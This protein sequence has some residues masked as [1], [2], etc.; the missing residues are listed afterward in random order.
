VFIPTAKRK[1]F[2]INWH[3]MGTKPNILNHLAPEEKLS[4][5]GKCSEKISPV[6]MAVIFAGIP[7]LFGPN[8]RRLLLFS[9]Q[10]H[11]S[12]FS[13]R[14]IAWKGLEEMEVIVT[15]IEEISSHSY[16]YPGPG[17]S[18][19]FSRIEKIRPSA[20]RA[21]VDNAPA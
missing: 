11:T 2:L 16:V 12:A 4:F 21:R 6:A 3:G 7:A 13:S 18:A 19:I 15:R 5:R 9:S 17:L 10:T 8:P 20:V 1:N 14:A